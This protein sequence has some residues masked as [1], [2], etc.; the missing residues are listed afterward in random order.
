MKQLARAEVLNQN[1]QEIDKRF[2]RLNRWTFLMMQ[3]FEAKRFLDLAETTHSVHLGSTFDEVL[4]QQALFRAF[5]LAYGKCFAAS[6]KG[7]SSLDPGKVF[8]TDKGALETHARIM[9]LRHKFAAH[10]DTSGLDQA[11]ID[12]HESESEF[13]I[14]HSYAIANPLHEY[15][16]YRNAIEVLEGYVVTQTNR[17]LSSLEKELGK[18]VRVRNA[19]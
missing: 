10:N 3:V 16:Q 19:G 12:V 15:A 5:L 14:S 7:R 8:G 2:G 9:D 11:V 18:P 17:A 6:G 4:T 1:G 13:V